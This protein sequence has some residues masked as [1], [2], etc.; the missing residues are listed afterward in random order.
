MRKS[1]KIAGIGCGFVL[2]LAIGFLAFVGWELRPRPATSA[3]PP[4]VRDLPGPLVTDIQKTFHARVEGKFANGIA[5]DALAAELR[6]EGFRLGDN[7]K[8][9][10]SR[11]RQGLVPPHYE[12]DEMSPLFFA[13]IEQQA[14]PCLQNWTVQWRRDAQGRAQK[15][16]GR[17]R[18]DCP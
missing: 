9:L 6:H 8:L 13:D 1:L 7:R 12:A 15:I 5:A 2:L 4:L 16:D 18:Y 10:A 17:Y 11:K 3:L 14:F